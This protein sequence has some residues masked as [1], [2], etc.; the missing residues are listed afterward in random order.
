MSGALRMAET[1]QILCAPAAST[2]SSVCKFTPPIANHG[3]VAD[4]VERHGLGGRFGAG[5]VDRADG[6]IV[7]SGSQRALRL[8]GSMRAQTNAEFRVRSLEFGDILES[9]VEKI[10]LA[11]VANVRTNFVRDLQ[12]VVDDEADLRTARDGQ[13]FFRQTPNFVGR[14]MLGPELNQ[15]TAA[16]TKLLRDEF[17]R[18]AMQIGRV[19]EGVKFAVREWFHFPIK[20]AAGISAAAVRVKYIY[21]KPAR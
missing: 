11:E 1:T 10:F 2:A 19:H 13:D 5:G 9:G 16:V 8:I 21:F 6:D 20:T 15:I 3:T 14:R 17:G 18:A 7:R 12:V 4:I